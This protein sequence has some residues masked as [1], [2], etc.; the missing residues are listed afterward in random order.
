[1]GAGAFMNNKRLE[2]VWFQNGR[3]MEELPPMAFS[4]CSA[5]S[6]VQL[7]KRLRSIGRRAFY[8]CEKLNGMELPLQLKYIGAEAFYGLQYRRAGAAGGAAGDWRGGIP[9]V[10]KA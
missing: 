10:Q 4:G 8:K 2:S 5:L 7:P 6:D 3:G 9:K 1:M